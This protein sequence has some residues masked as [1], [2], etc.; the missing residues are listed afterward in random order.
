MAGGQN[1]VG[2]SFEPRR[3]T[4][5]VSPYYRLSVYLSIVR[6]AVRLF[7]RPRERVCV[8]VSESEWREEEISEAKRGEVRWAS[9]DPP[10]L[11][12]V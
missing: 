10:G 8:R 12:I 5:R 1:M 6:S 7:Y 2:V 3:L 11:D 4:G 9:G